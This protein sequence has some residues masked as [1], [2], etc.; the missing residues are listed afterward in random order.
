MHTCVLSTRIVLDVF[1]LG[2]VYPI[3]FIKISVLDKEAI[4]IASIILMVCEVG[5]AILSAI[6]VFNKKHGA[7][8]TF[9]MVIGEN[10]LSYMSVMDYIIRYH[11]DAVN[12]LAIKNNK[13]IPS[14]LNTG[15]ITDDFMYDM[16]HTEIKISL[17]LQEKYPCIFLYT[18]ES[19]EVLNRFVNSLQ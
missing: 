12:K 8:G 15:Y 16:T 7:V 13:I 10:D 2:I 9:S 17:G 1:L 3:L 5:T 14:S 4:Y 11:T 19:T 18:D 6:V